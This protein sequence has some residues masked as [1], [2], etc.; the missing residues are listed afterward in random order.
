MSS[1]HTPSPKSPENEKIK[2]YDRQLR[3]WG[4]N[5]QLALET[6]HVCLINANVV[7][8]EILKNLVLPGIR[9]FTIIDDQTVT[10]DDVD[11]NFF[12]WPE[13]SIGQS[14]AK[15]AAH[16]LLEMNEDVKKGDYIQEKFEILLEKDLDFFKNFT[17][18]IAC[19]ICDEDSLNKL[20]RK[21]WSINVPLLVAKSIGF[22]GYIRLQI[23]EHPVLEPHPDNSLDDLRLD[24]LFPELQSYFDSFPNFDCL[25][26]TELSRIPSL[27]IIYRNLLK[28]REHYQKSANTIPTNYSEKS[29]LISL[30]KTNMFELKDRFVALELENFEEAIKLANKIFYDS[31]RIPDNLRKLL[32]E[33]NRRDSKLTIN[34]NFWTMVKALN[35]FLTIYDGHLPLNG[36]IPD[37][38][39]GSEQYI[40]LQKIYKQKAKD[41]VNRLQQILQDNY[42]TIAISDFDINLF[43]KNVRNLIVLRTGPMFDDIFNKSMRLLAAK[44]LQNC[45]DEEDS[46]SDILRFYIL[47]RLIDRFYSKHRRFPG[48][49]DDEV[50]VSELK[51]EFRDFCQDLGS[52]I[53]IND[54]SFHEIC[55]YGGCELHSVSAFLGGCAAQEAIKIITSQYVPID[56]TFVYNGLSGTTFT[57]KI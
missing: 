21:L 56:N 5:G 55:R 10:E 33:A 26:R 14:R 24:H 2:R 49:N 4:E 27:V 19:G 32:A 41:D 45:T 16:F 23:E 57:Y 15:V 9:A 43:C 51:R 8:T 35:D 53:V 12:L 46:D 3:L 44:N 1:I 37:M 48:Q 52:H 38:N 25:D 54:E 22:L 20:S 6:S 36:S 17:L 13:E 18:V 39:S 40:R 47:M 28:W 42:K 31:D 50:D 30:I 7:G 34:S 29:E 11:S